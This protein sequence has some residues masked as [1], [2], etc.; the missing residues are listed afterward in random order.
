MTNMMTILS[1]KNDVMLVIG[2]KSAVF[3]A[4]VRKISNAMDF[5]KRN[6]WKGSISWRMIGVMTMTMTMMVVV[7]AVVVMMM[8][9]AV[10]VVVLVVV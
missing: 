5:Q 10:R 7:A 9:V 4:L 2:S 8:V 6:R 1:L 3:V